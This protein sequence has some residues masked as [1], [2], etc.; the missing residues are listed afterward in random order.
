MAHCIADLTAILDHLCIER[1]DLL[2]YSMGGRV[3]LA[4]AVARPERVGAL[5]LEGASAGIADDVQRR[6]RR[7]C[8]A[9][10]AD[11]IEREGIE[12]FVDAW[13]EQPLFASQTRLGAKRLAAERRRRYANDPIGLA[14]N[15]RGLGAGAQEPLWERLREVS[16][17]TLLIAG[18]EDEK[19]RGIAIDMSS[20]M[21]C[22][23]VR[24]IPESGHAVHLENPAAFENVVR[25]FLR[26]NDARSRLS[27]VGEGQPRV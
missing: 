18:E 24:F 2:G 6:D 11:L 3:A 10:W 21:S 5:V 19:F 1:T 12:A 7:R 8:D 25:D 9:R 26:R 27:R 20:R 23:E 14:N 16:A 17:P 22:A 13:M 15:L 4:F